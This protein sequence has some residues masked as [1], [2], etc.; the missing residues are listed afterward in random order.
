VQRT[1]TTPS[2]SSQP[3]CRTLVV[4]LQQIAQNVAGQAGISVH[5]IRSDQQI[6]E[7]VT[8]RPRPPPPGRWPAAAPGSAA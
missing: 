5:N 8:W 7:R 4:F 6:A 1:A 3:L 2:Q